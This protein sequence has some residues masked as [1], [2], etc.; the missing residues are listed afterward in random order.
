[1]RIAHG[2][3]LMTLSLRGWEAF[4]TPGAL[5]HTKIT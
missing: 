1:M 4:P 5:T 2:F 3:T